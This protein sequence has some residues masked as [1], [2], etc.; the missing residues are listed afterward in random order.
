[1]FAATE[2]RHTGVGKLLSD[3]ADRKTTAATTG[4]IIFNDRQ[5]VKEKTK[6]VREARF[7]DNETWFLVE[8]TNTHRHESMG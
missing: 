3:S 2:S 7:S 4:N 8:E 1:M 6:K 5:T